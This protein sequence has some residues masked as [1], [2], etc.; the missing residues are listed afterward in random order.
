[1]TSPTVRAAVRAEMARA[2]VRQQDLADHLGFNQ[3]AMSNRLCGV[4][5]FKDWE[6]EEIATYLGCPLVALVPEG[7]HA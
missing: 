1:M 2:G 4:T 6:I 7:C 5:P 3:R